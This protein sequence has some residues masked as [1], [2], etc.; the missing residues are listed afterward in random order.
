VTPAANQSGTAHITLTVSDGT[1]TAKNIFMLTVN[2]PGNTPPTITAISN[3]TIAENSATTALAFTVGDAETPGS[4]MLAAT[5]DNP[6]LVPDANIAIGGSNPDF[7]V[8][9]PPTANNYGVANITITVT[10]AS[11]AT[12]TAQFS[13]TVVAPPTISTV[14]D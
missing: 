4:L 1:L 3:Q 7:T 11:G 9:V 12:A 8:T 14:S 13:V 5:S 2:S 6:A 10:D